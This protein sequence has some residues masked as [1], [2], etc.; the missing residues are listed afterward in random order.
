MAPGWRR[1]HLP[2]QQIGHFRLAVADPAINNADKSPE[3]EAHPAENDQDASWNFV[4]NPYLAYYQLDDLGFE[5]PITYWDGYNYVAV[6]PGDD[7]YVFQPYQ[8]FFVQKPTDTGT[9]GFDAVNQ[10]TH[11]QSQT[12]VAQAR[13]RRA[14]Q[15]INPARLIINVTLSD[16]EN[17]D[18]TRVVYNNEKSASYEMAC[19]AAKFMSTEAVPQLFTVNGGVQYAINERPQGEVEL[20]F[21]SPKAGTYTISM[22][23]MDAPMLLKDLK[24]GVTFDFTVGEE[25]VFEAEAGTN[26]SRFV[27]LLNPN[28]NRIENMTIADAENAQFYNLAGQLTDG[29]SNAI[30]IMKQGNN[31]KKL[32]IR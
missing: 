14:R 11:T 25:Y 26:T 12:A 6:R 30:Q 18:R 24:T 22:A 9:V 10:Q 3:L 17:T 28:T 27:L 1:L 31:A 8:A 21:K 2:V 16:G 32:M 13:E 4:G 15:R 5:A 7:D 19:D 20:G 23:R 29:E